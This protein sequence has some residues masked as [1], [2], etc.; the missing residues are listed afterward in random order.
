ML[1][2]GKINDDWQVQDITF[3]A[4]RPSLAP[5]TPWVIGGLGDV[6][7]KTGAVQFKVA[8]ALAGPLFQWTVLEQPTKVSV[9]GI[10]L[11]EAVADAHPYTGDRLHL[12]MLDRAI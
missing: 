11:N 3:T 10:E 8:Y 4:V 7:D 5:N 9:L 2:S 1:I 6:A 12:E